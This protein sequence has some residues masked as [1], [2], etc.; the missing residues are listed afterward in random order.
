MQD[1]RFCL[2]QGGKVQDFLVGKTL[3][4]PVCVGVLL[5]WQQGLAQLLSWL[6]F[7]VGIG[8]DVSE[9]DR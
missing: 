8:S 7:V 3:P 6:V 9:L 2:G 5:L 4:G 1:M